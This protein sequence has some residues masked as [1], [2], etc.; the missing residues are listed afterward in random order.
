MRC[1]APAALLLLA[2]LPVL[3]ATAPPD[4]WPAFRGTGD[5]ISD[6]KALPLK[7]SPTENVAWTTELPGYGQ[8]SPVV[9]ADRV[10]VTSAEG[11]FKDTLH[12]LRLDLA[13][14]KEAWR[15]SYPNAARVKATDYVSKS[16]PTPVVT[17]GV[18]AVRER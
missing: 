3:R 17:A 15:K 13:T 7:W 10:F 1:L 9:W 12:V 16:A 2:A 8:S 5:S 11:E 18:R 4:R 6:A 14:G